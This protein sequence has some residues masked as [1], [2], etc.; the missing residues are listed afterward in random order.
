MN[1][2][3]RYSVNTQIYFSYIYI[4]L[5]HIWVY[6]FGK[7]AA[8]F[9]GYLTH[10]NLIRTAKRKQSYIVHGNVLDLINHKNISNY[11]H[12]TYMY[13]FIVRIVLPKHFI[14]CDAYL[15]DI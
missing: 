13:D 7:Y 11:L 6:V 8:I 2:M 10:N 1:I 9:K 14:T 15:Y 3:A 12:I 4:Y 5:L